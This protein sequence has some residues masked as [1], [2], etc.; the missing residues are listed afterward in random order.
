MDTIWIILCKL[1]KIC[2]NGKRLFKSKYFSDRQI[3]LQLSN[4]SY[5]TK[6]SSHDW[7]ELCSLG[8]CFLSLAQALLQGDGLGEALRKQEELSE[9]VVTQLMR[10]Q[11]ALFA[12]MRRIAES[13]LLRRRTK[14]SSKGPKPAVPEDTLVG[15]KGKGYKPIKFIARGSGGCVFSAVRVEVSSKLSKLVG[16]Q[17][18]GEKDEAGPQVSTRSLFKLKNAVRTQLDRQLVLKQIDPAQKSSA[19]NEY[20]VAQKLR[21]VDTDDRCITYLDRAVAEDGNLWLLL[22]RI[23]PSSYGIDLAQYIESKFFQ[24]HKSAHQQFSRGIVVSLLEGLVVV[25]E[26]GVVMRDVKPDNVLIEEEERKTKDGFETHYVARW[27]D[28]G[29]SVDMSLEG[30]RSPSRLTDPNNKDELVESLV[31][32]W[33]DT[34]VCRVSFALI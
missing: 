12:A 32:F 30:V 31:G 9:T 5:Q 16:V 7:P 23:R 27:S 25:A 26:A 6:L 22:R 10:H 34:Q 19:E 2:R 4:G 28:F 17:P 11:D 14:G 18:G 1:L 21:A 15:E 8:P 3:L 20:R 33:Y 29:L 13:Y 24:L